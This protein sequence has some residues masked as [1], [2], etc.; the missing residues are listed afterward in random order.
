MASQGY[1]EHY[2]S[3]KVIHGLDAADALDDM[4]VFHAATR[5][6]EHFTVT[7][8]GRVL[9]ITALGCD[10]ATARDK[11]YDAVRCIRFDNA[12]WRSDIAERAP[13]R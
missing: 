6:V 1:P 5:R 11:A 7:D 9:G 4:A 13:E 10:A 8:G 3:G 2:E 12:Y